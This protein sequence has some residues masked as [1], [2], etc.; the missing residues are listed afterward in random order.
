M[1]NQPFKDITFRASHY[2]TAENSQSMVRHVR[3]G[4]IFE[5]KIGV[6]FVPL[7]EPQYPLIETPALDLR[8]DERD[9]EYDFDR[10]RQ[11]NAHNAQTRELSLGDA[12]LI[13]RDTQDKIA[14]IQRFQDFDAY[15]TEDNEAFMNRLSAS[16]IELSP[17]HRVSSAWNLYFGDDPYGEILLVQTKGGWREV[18][19]YTSLELHT[20]GQTGD[21]F[22]TWG[23]RPSQFGYV[24]KRPTGT[25]DEKVMQEG[26]SNDV[27]NLV[28]HYYIE[29]LFVAPLLVGKKPAPLVIHDDLCIAEGF[30]LAALTSTQGRYGAVFSSDK[31]P[32]TVF[33]PWKIQSKD[34][35]NNVEILLSQA[36]A[37]R[38]YDGGNLVQVPDSMDSFKIEPVAR[39][40]F[41]TGRPYNFANCLFVLARDPA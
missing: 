15:S 24:E 31:V 36:T 13:D 39:K 10:A 35:K 16:G 26:F 40:F 32:A 5:D 14:I 9:N 37:A 22:Y 7:K 11:V 41:E 2:E 27:K 4:D 3:S 19:A 21:Q 33:V 34:G 8:R 17:V 12:R 23:M 18:F 28:C 1:T 25:R 6:F 29:N 20:A 30:R 38:L